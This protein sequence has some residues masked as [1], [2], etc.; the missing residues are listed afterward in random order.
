MPL[1]TP[2]LFMQW[3]SILLPHVGYAPARTG[4]TDT[5]IR[6]DGGQISVPAFVQRLLGKDGLK[7]LLTNKLESSV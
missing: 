3:L 7:A 4:K 1:W 2:R 6:P 5:E